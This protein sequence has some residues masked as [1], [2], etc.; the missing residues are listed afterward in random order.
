M[1]SKVRP[2]SAPGTAGPAPGAD[3]PRHI[4]IVACSAEGAALCYRT[5]CAEGAALLGPHAHPEVSLHSASLAD[6][7][8]CLDR[9]DLPGVAALMLDSAR[10]LAA[11]GADFLI[12]PDNTIHQAFAHVAAATPLPW[13]HIAEV[14]AAE[15]AARGYRRLGLLGTRWLVDSEV[16]PDKLGERGIACV[17]PD[18]AARDDIGRIIMDELVA[19]IVK[20]ESIA[21]FQ[22]VIRGLQAEGCDAMVL[23]CTEIPLVID[24][25]NSALPTLDS[26]RLLARAALRRAVGGGSHPPPTRPAATS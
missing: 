2:A 12:C 4:G 22:S 20:S 24:D 7:V 14:V 25:G 13:L 18:D 21:T 16:Y 5:V 6:Y 1:T 10:K 19:G 8:H 11:A 3:R 15:A 26:T 9:G 17:R 23:G